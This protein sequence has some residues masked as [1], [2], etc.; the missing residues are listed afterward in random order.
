LDLPGTDNADLDTPQP[1]IPKI[2]IGG[3]E[4]R[5]NRRLQDK[6]KDL[7]MSSIVP[8]KR[9]K[10]LTQVVTC[11]MITHVYIHY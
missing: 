3:E 6:P 7:S 10:F 11:K 9:K 4:H 5:E 1:Q 8:K 2:V